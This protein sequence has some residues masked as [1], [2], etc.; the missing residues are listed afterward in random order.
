MDVQLYVYDLSQGL[1]RQYSRALTGIQ[2]DA[3]YHTAIV[4]NNVEYFFGQ[5]IHRKIPGSTHHGRPIQVVDLG[6]THLPIDV[7]EE[8]VESLAEIYTPESYDLFLHNCNNFSQDLAMFLVG[9]SIPDE[10]RSLPETFLKTPIGQMLRGQIDQSMRKMTQAPDAVA[11]RNVSSSSATT[12]PIPKPTTNGASTT[13][14]SNGTTHKLPSTAIIN[15]QPPSETPGQVHYI[16]SPSELDRLLE[17]ARDSCAVIFFTSATCPPCKIVYPTYDEL[18]AEAGTR[19]GAKLI[20]IDISA[21]P[22][23]NAVA[24]RYQVRATPT[25]ITFLKGQK[26]EEWAGAN[27]AQLKGNVRLLLQMAQPPQHRHSSL[28]LPTFQ[29]TIGKPI[30]YTRT[31]PLDKL[32]AKIGPQFTQDQS[33]QDLLAYIK[34][35]DDQGMTEAP[36]PNLH[37]FSDHLASSFASLPANTHFA[38]ID[39]VRV[40]AVDPRVS[41]FFA[42]E[43]ELKTLS[44]LLSGTGYSDDFSNAPYN[45]QAV[46]LQL[47]CNLFG[48]NVFQEQ[49]F[50][51]QSGSSNGGS[52]L[53]DK[54]ETL[55]S[56]CLLSP[57]ANARSMA[58]ALVYNLSAYMHNQRMHN[59]PDEDASPNDDLS[60]ALL[61]SL[62]SLSS[63]VSGPASSAA[64]TTETLHALL[65]AL[66]MLLYAAPPEDMLWDLCRAM[67]LREALKEIKAS[68]LGV[69]DEPLLKEVGDE[70]LGKGAF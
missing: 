33:V 40:A 68:D 70:L 31:P 6:K 20:K 59:T 22:S 23:A 7:V 46:S 24:Q 9:K 55:A 11:G 14:I 42:A 45:I 48:S 57:H 67:D 29:R 36:I 52:S 32:L 49:V 12:K 5:G 8:Y 10:I 16:S 47:A 17:A 2:I 65:L 54:I 4:F 51:G 15:A 34:T 30:M 56:Q 18:A 25:F 66:G 41:S 27:P 43:H 26:Q 64:S 3:I 61:E 62:T 69:K 63:V 21:S 1:A 19:S 39:L 38:V 60:A 28:R 13:P 50:R 53:K 58:A 37:A 35:R 44:T